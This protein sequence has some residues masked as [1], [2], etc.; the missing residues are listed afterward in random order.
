[1]EVWPGSDGVI[2]RDKRA[3]ARVDLSSMPS[4]KFKDGSPQSCVVCGSVSHT[5]ELRK[6]A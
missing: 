6:L 1:M 4:Q 3:L 2:S 5:S